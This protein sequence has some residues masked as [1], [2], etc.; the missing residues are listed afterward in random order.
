[1]FEKIAQW[2]RNRNIIGG[3]EAVDQ[4]LKYIEE[5]GEF[6]GGIAKRNLDVIKDSV[7]DCMVV[8]VM[9]AGIYGISC[10]YAL[11]RQ[12][13][14]TP[15]DASA[16]SDEEMVTMAIAL[17]TGQALFQKQSNSRLMVNHLKIALSVVDEG[18]SDAERLDHVGETILTLI[19]LSLR[20][21][22][23]FIECVN[24]A[25]DEIKDRRGRIVDGVF[26]KQADLI[27]MDANTLEAAGYT[28]IA[29]AWRQ[30]MQ[31]GD[32]P[33]GRYTDLTG[34][35]LP[36]LA[37]QAGVV[38]LE[39]ATFDVTRAIGDAEII[40]DVTQLEAFAEIEHSDLVGVLWMQQ[41]TQPNGVVVER[42]VVFNKNTGTRRGE[43][44]TIDELVL[45]DW[46]MA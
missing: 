37:E 24:I 14:L 38:G 15:A 12:L 18:I 16:M 31:E 5:S 44:D 9:K 10:S 42:R 23:D 43:L 19:A 2:G 40:S 32:R 28:D 34:I 41:E 45:T 27:E 20:Q 26:V 22:V 21:D 3:A 1:M 35:T 17:I 30:L 46:Q 11:S 29:L 33:F 39:L 6:A 4:A 8:E 36:E 7:G 13:N 25:Y